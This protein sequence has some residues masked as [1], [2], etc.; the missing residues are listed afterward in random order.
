MFGRK[1]QE[2]R[3][4]GK[5]RGCD[6][7]GVGL[8]CSEWLQAGRP[9]REALLGLTELSLSLPEP[10]VSL[11]QCEQLVA[12]LQSSVRQAVQL[13]HLVRVGHPPVGRQSISEVLNIQSIMI[14]LLH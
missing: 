4:E 12:E 11:E 10:A 5:W 1:R 9:E 7:L 2:E 13:Y 8:S 3:T 14:T 6:A